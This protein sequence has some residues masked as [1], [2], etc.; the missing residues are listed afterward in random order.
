MKKHMFSYVSVV[1]IPPTCNDSYDLIT[2]IFWGRI[3]GTGMIV[4]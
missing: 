3:A 2:H 4:W 1:V